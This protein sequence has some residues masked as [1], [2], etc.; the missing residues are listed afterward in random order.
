MTAIPVT[1]LITAV[2]TL[3]DRGAGWVNGAAATIIVPRPTIQK[4]KVMGLGTSRR[5]TC[6]RA[7][8][9][10]VLAAARPA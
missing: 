4:K 3:L 7:V 8:A 1:R 10:S 2:K 9:R 6:R 5:S